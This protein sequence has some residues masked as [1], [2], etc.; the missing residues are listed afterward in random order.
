[1]PIEWWVLALLIVAAFVAGWVDAVVGGGGLIQ[2]PAVFYGLP[3]QTVAMVSGTNKTSSVAGTA[4]A[5]GTYLR[6]LRLAAPLALCLCMCAYAGSS[7][8]AALNHHLD[9][10]IFTPLLLAV[11]IAVGVYT[12]RRPSLGMV[13]GERLTGWRK[14]AGVCLIGLGVGFYDGLIGPGTGTFFI[15]LIVAFLGYGFLKA[16]AYAK[17]ANLTTNTAAI[18]VFASTHNILWAVALPM[19]AAN[20]TGGWLGAR[21]ALKHGNGFVRKVFLVVVG[22]LSLRLAWDTV[23]LALRIF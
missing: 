7:A 17:L 12:W 8:G 23:Q 3:D 6:R 5:T 11:L 19:A 10:D 20:L 15:I 22:L 13:D 4:M 18:V 1:M 14:L 2:L 9:R 21:L 16:S